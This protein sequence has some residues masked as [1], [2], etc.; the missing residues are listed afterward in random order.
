MERAADIGS[1]DSR[2][3]RAPEVSSGGVSG[4]S[5]DGASAWP[6]ALVS[7]A[8]V[9]AAAIFAGLMPLRFSIITVFLF[10][11]PHNLFELRYFLSRL[12]ARLGRSRNFF[13]VAF[14][15][16]ALLL[17]AYAAL[18]F[19]AG[20]LVWGG[21]EWTVAVGVWNSLLLL[22]LGALVWM[23]GRQS[24]RR[25]WSWGFAVAFALAG[26]NWL[27]P[28]VFSLGL[29]YV[30]P[31]VALWFLDRHLRRTRPALRRAYHLC[32]ATLPF[33]VGLIWWQLIDAPAL[34]ADAGDPLALRI[35][36]H[37][38]SDILQGVS[39]H[40]L[41]STHVFL[42]TVHYGVWLLALPL[43]RVRRGVGDGGGNDD[44]A[45]W[46]RI[47]SLPLARHTRRGRPRLIRA[48]L[49]VSAACV[50]LLWLA[51]LADYSTT[52]DLYFTLAMAHVLAE[53]PFLL[54]ML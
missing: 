53:A 14:A 8:V 46:W 19:V 52:R 24:P 10:A 36:R 1:V 42:E 50:V 38:G 54:R 16:V 26:A 6:F 9:A 51:F 41:V 44:A 37:A 20:A 47:E 25:D 22:W 21:D 27:A 33:F 48:A 18:P 23:R 49:V 35:T 39:S 17:A 5:R 34:P 30:H 15:G 3:A 32:L 11:G 43:L 7:L 31:L 29:V 12:P 4:A 13:L 45:P 40:L 2:A 28:Q